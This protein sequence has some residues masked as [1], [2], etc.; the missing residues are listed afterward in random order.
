MKKPLAEE[1]ETAL[2]ADLRRA[3]K[4]YRTVDTAHRPQA[5]QQYIE[6]LHRFTQFV[7]DG[8]WPDEP[9]KRSA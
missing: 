1:V 9:V 3:E 5:R 2:L 7:V 6:A 8:I 4:I